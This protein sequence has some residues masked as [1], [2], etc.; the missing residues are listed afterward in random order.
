M[1]YALWGGVILRPIGEG[2]TAPNCCSTFSTGADFSYGRVNHATVPAQ[3]PR[4]QAVDAPGPP[5]PPPRILRA[6][7]CWDPHHECHLCN[8]FRETAPPAMNPAF[9]HCGTTESFLASAVHA[10]F[11]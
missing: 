8:T 4:R 9:L 11:A 6:I 10:A 2:Q 1:W 3:S 5:P 7:R